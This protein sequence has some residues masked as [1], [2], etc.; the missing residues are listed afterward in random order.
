MERLQQQNFYQTQRILQQFKKIQDNVTSH[1]DAVVASYVANNSLALQKQNEQKS[2]IT[3]NSIFE[4]DNKDLTFDSKD[5]LQDNYQANDINYNKK[6]SQ[7]SMNGIPSQ[8]INTV[9]KQEFKGI[10]NEKEGI[11]QNI[12]DFTLQ[13]I[14]KEDVFNFQPSEIEINEG[15][16][17]YSQDIM[18]I[19]LNHMNLFWTETAITGVRMISKIHQLQMTRIF[20][21]SLT[22]PA[23]INFTQ[24]IDSIDRK[25]LLQE[26]ADIEDPSKIIIMMSRGLLNLLN[27]AN[28]GRFS[29]KVSWPE[30]RNEF[31][32]NNVQLIK[33]MRLFER[34][35]RLKR[36][37][38]HQTKVLNDQYLNSIEISL[39]LK[40]TKRHF[41]FDVIT[42]LQQG[43]HYMGLIIDKKI[44]QLTNPMDY[45]TNSQNRQKLKQKQEAKSKETDDNRHSRAFQILR[46]K[47]TDHSLNPADKDKLLP[48]GNIK[49]RFEAKR[50]LSP[51]QT[52]RNLISNTRLQKG[53]NTQS[54]IQQQEKSKAEDIG[55]TS[56]MNIQNGSNHFKNKKDSCKYITQVLQ[57]KDK[58]QSQKRSRSYLSSISHN[59][60]LTPQFKLSD[61][62]LSISSNQG[63]K[64]QK[65]KNQMSVHLNKSNHFS[66]TLKN[67]SCWDDNQMDEPQLDG[68]PLQ[69]QV[70][71][72]DENLLEQHE[73]HLVNA[74]FLK[75]Q[76]RISMPDKDL[77]QSVISQREKLAD[78]LKSIQQQILKRPRSIERKYQKTYHQNFK[79][80]ALGQNYSSIQPIGKSNINAN[81]NPSINTQQVKPNQKPQSANKNQLPS[82]IQQPYQ[83]LLQP[84]LTKSRE[85]NK[86]Q[87]NQNSSTQQQQQSA[88]HQD[89]QQ[90][91]MITQ[92]INKEN[93]S[94]KSKG[95]TTA[96]KKDLP[97]WTQNQVL[98]EKQKLEQTIK[99]ITRNT[100]QQ[101]QYRTTQNISG[102]SMQYEQT[103]R[104]SVLQ[105]ST[106]ENLIK[107]Q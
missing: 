48:F 86:P 75:T 82:T 104:A 95:Y 22:H 52:T 53:G 30:I 17:N 100:N 78:Q 11:L 8:N 79:T 54:F 35:A 6:Q 77:K 93:D 65:R 43:V 20:S 32:V 2:S 45:Q 69:Q 28:N 57:E 81:A 23:L 91:T 70:V 58:E 61:N 9:N 71:F 92:I 40:S 72:T 38:E 5:F 101:Q 42:Y 31:R 99:N 73:N 80:S 46:R 55:E 63:Q 4:N 64:R 98:K 51:F 107:K 7:I 50:N 68:Y 44:Q 29:D 41:A 37:S 84:V 47:Q 83:S 36:F 96:K 103:S 39:A 85:A 87:I 1:A 21:I 3:I 67:N 59:R 33:Q 88:S 105:Q 34:I 49:N 89:I 27:L 106:Q 97:S 25:K 19:N 76:S 90:R 94:Q 102:V 24:I 18:K 62:S 13:N 60:T 10:L 12:N 74:E 16:N 15:S 66:K 56:V 14:I 26:M